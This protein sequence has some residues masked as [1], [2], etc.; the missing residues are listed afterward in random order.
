MLSMSKLSAY[1]AEADMVEQIANI[2]TELHLIEHQSQI[3][4]DILVG[5][6]FDVNNMRVMQPDEMIELYISDEY[7]TASEVEFRKAIE[8]LPFV[9]DSIEY[10][11]KIWS[12]VIKRDNWLAVNMDA[13]L[14]KISETSFYKLVELCFLLDG[15][16][17]TTLPP[18]DT[19]L[20]APE[21]AELLSQKS[22]QYLLKL[23]F[24][25]ISETFK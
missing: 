18:I 20:T 13:P 21:L 10:R 2:N 12:A 9:D 5:V 15:E 8:L 7:T 23:T 25:H 11:N 16:V 17:G 24:E 3:D 14:D 6:G 22:F 19:F 4:N 1:A